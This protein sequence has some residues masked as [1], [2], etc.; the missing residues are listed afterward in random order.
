MAMEVNLTDAQHADKVRHAAQVLNAVIMEASRAGIDVAI[1]MV[2]A[3]QI[4]GGEC[5]LASVVV[6]K[7]L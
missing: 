6:R 3:T 5:R 1:D 7:R 4:G 2:D